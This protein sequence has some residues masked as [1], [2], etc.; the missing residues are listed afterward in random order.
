VKSFEGLR[1]QAGQSVIVE[2]SNNSRYHI[3]AHA[4]ATISKEVAKAAGPGTIA[5]AKA[6]TARGSLRA[7]SN[8]NQFSDIVECCD[9]V[10][11]DRREQTYWSL[12]RQRL[13]CGP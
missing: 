9:V 6:N 5:V 4:N 2:G 12:A 10:W 11:L 7:S 8:G 13:L 3:G 1:A